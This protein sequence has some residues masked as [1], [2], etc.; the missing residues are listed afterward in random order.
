MV[1]FK[2][3]FNSALNSKRSDLRDTE[4]Q[5]SKVPKTW[6]KGTL[7]WQ[8]TPTSIYLGSLPGVTFYN[9]LP[10]GAPYTVMVLS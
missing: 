3:Q 9:A 1:D 5:L 7:P 10:Q 6:P 8:D 4:F 2:N